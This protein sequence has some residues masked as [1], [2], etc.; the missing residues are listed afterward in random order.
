MQV[1]IVILIIAII[2]V[3]ISMSAIIAGCN[4]EDRYDSN[5]KKC[6]KYQDPV[7]YNSCISKQTYKENLCN[8]YFS[9]LRLDA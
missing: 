5:Q 6:E 1:R 7:Q 4:S 2:T 3:I 9:W 8:D